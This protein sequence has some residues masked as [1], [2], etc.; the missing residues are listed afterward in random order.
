MFV[1]RVGSGK[2]AI[3]ITFT[4]LGY[5]VILGGNMSGASILD[6]LGSL[7]ACQVVIAED[8]L[9]NLKSDAEKWRLYTIGYDAFGL[10]TKTLDGSTSKRAISYYPAFNYKIFGAEVSLDTTGLEGLI[11]RTFQ[12]ILLK[13]KPNF[14]I[15][16]LR[17][18]NLSSKYKA[19]LSEITYFRKAML[20]YRLLHTN[21]LFE[22][23][24]T[25][26]DGRALS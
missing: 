6:L 26:I 18:P 16:K 13:G 11:D 1:A 22:E 5:R 8:E 15:K 10:T 19:L 7:E 4:Y 3:L 14:Y 23:V 20:I 25:N 2:G 12:T 24:E 17:K 9:N 21:D